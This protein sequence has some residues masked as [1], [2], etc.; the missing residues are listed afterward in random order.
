MNYFVQADKQI[1]LRHGRVPDQHEID[2]QLENTPYM[3][4]FERNDFEHKIF[5]NVMREVQRDGVDLEE[6]KE[7]TNNELGYVIFL[8]SETMNF[9]LS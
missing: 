9:S 5:T 7:S 2:A 3:K 4:W 8:L 6:L 1:L